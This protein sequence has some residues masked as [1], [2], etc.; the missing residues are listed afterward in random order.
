MKKSFFIFFLFVN[1]FLS[2][3]AFSN[4]KIVFIDIDLIINTS[5]AGKD[6]NTQMQKVVNEK[7][8]IFKDQETKLIEKEQKLISQKN[9]LK[10]EEFNVKINSFKKE[11]NEY[12]NKKKKTLQNLDKANKDAKLKIYDI[13]KQILAE[14]SSKND[15]SMIVDK[16]NV[17]I[18][19]KKFEITNLILDELNNKIKNV[20]LNL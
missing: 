20:K 6:V 17:I 18:G 8:K 9:L 10:E 19:N 1:F 11:Y 15:I 13:L 2:E 16:K 5:K 4:E 3:I 14:Y 7:N 12:I